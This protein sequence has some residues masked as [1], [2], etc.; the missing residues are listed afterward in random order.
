MTGLTVRIFRGTIFKH[1]RLH[2]KLLGGFPHLKYVCS[3][4]TRIL[5]I[6]YFLIS[7]FLLLSCRPFF[8]F[9][10]ILGFFFL[11]FSASLHTCGLCVKRILRLSYVNVAHCARLNNRNKVA[12]V[13][14]PTTCPAWGQRRLRWNHIITGLKMT[15]MLATTPSH[16]DIRF[17]NVELNI[18]AHV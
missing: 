14:R 12:F 5:S 6:V 16:L 11:V 2:L 17:Y 13:W 3:I 8:F 4:N 1:S 9:F 18:G 10:W 15:R 7:C